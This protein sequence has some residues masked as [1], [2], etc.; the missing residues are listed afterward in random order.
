MRQ[1]LANEKLCPDDY[2]AAVLGL[3]ADLDELCNE[4]KLAH[5]NS[6]EPCF[7]CPANV[8]DLPWTDFS[9]E[10][11]AVL[12]AYTP[13]PTGTRVEPPSPHAVW[14]YGLTHHSALWDV[15]HGCDLG[16]C[17]H[18]CGNILFDLTRNPNLGDSVDTRMDW[19]VNHIDVFYGQ[20]GIENRIDSLRLS[21][22]CNPDAPDASFP[23]L[24]CKANEARHLLPCLLEILRLVFFIPSLCYF[25]CF[26]F[27]HNQVAY[28]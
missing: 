27:L 3:C 15:M 1:K 22:F 26:S 10:G 7:C 4:Y 19:V 20:L 25:V 18:V 14:E 12:L 16:P 23:I 11:A 17:L 8:T 24:K 6:N 5:Y 21:V 28:L 13:A 9:E 2:C